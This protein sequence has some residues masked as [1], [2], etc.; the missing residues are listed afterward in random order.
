MARTLAEMSKQV[1]ELATNLPV[2]ANALKQQA[3][4]TVNFGLL[5]DTP[6]DTGLAVSNWQVNLDAAATEPRPAFV[7]SPEGKTSHKK[8][9]SSRVHVADPEAVRQAN[10]ALALP[11][12]NETID[13]SS[14]GQPIHLTNVLPYIKALD[15][16]HSAQA[17]L[18]VDRSIIRAENLVSRASLLG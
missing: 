7:P 11:L 10:I 8:G 14:P 5:Q 2:R 18:F 1:R 17:E 12:A 9:V 4:R 15:E 16:G 3:A 6:V 13:S